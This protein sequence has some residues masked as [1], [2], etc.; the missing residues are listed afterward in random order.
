MR[1]KNWAEGKYY[2]INKMKFLSGYIKSGQ[3]AMTLIET[4]FVLSVITILLAMM[5]PVLSPTGRP[6]PQ[7]K[8]RLQIRDIVT[9]IIAYHNDYG[10]YPVP[11]N[12]EARAL[13]S[14]TDFTYGGPELNRILGPGTAT[15]V[16]ADVIAVLMDFTNFPGGGPTVNSN[17]NLNPRQIAYLKAILTSHTN[18]P[19]VGIDLVYRDPWGHP[20]IITMDLNGDGRC[21]DAF[22][23]KF[24]VSQ[25]SGTVGFNGLTNAYTPSGRS[26]L[27]ENSGGVMVRRWAHDGKADASLPATSPTNKDNVLSWIR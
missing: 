23:K 27:F 20:Y 6:T 7:R 15:P 1:F 21:R 13:A 16:N 9:A 17:H 18:S 5:L 4:L 2:S 19:G 3:R 11:T 10:R 8:A 26:D 25:Q 22:Y 24:A 12:I 14:K